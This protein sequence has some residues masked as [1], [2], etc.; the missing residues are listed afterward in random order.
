M[1]HVILY[2]IIKSLA[3][4][5]E[6]DYENICFSFTVA[7]QNFP[8]RFDW[9][10]T[11]VVTPWHQCYFKVNIKVYDENTNWVSRN[12]FYV[13][14]ADWESKT[15]IRDAVLQ[16]IYKHITFPSAINGKGSAKVFHDSVNKLNDEIRDFYSEE[17]YKGVVD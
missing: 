12:A 4:K 3:T 17:K 2:E 5:F 16:I 15:V 9:Q 7:E 8:V 11:R 6:T 10:G 1:K 13:P 14:L